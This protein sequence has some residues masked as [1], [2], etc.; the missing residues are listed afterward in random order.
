METNV[1]KPDNVDFNDIENEI[2]LNPLERSSYKF[3]AQGLDEDFNDMRNMHASKVEMD[4][5]PVGSPE[6]HIAAAKMY[7]HIINHS[8]DMVRFHHEN[9]DTEKQLRHQNIIN[10]AHAE[11]SH[12]LAQ[13]HFSMAKQHATN[14]NLASAI[15]HQV[16]GEAEQ[17][18][19]TN[20]LHNLNNTGE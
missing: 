2:N 5:H 12:H 14:G 9:G 13:Y 17:Q 10:N 18:R 16:K 1:V 8:K 11:V 6:H 3:F 19:H 4:S 20:L 7:G 15:R